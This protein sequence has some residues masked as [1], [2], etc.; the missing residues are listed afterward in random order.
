MNEIRKK[1]T[2]IVR[3]NTISHYSVSKIF[4]ITS[5][6]K[7]TVL[8]ETIEKCQTLTISNE[9]KKITNNGL[10]FKFNSI[11]KY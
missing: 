7:L 5:N 6:V 8:F 2:T 1:K 9:A 11:S 4:E 3:N 10:F